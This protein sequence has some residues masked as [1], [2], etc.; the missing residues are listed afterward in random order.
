MAPAA[1]WACALGLGLLPSQPHVLVPLGA[2]ALL[3]AHHY[4]QLEPVVLGPVLQPVLAAL[5]L[6]PAL[7][8]PVRCLALLPPLLGAEPIPRG[9]T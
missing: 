7:L 4:V 3:V 9:G 1:Q 6:G 8:A 2:V 5:V